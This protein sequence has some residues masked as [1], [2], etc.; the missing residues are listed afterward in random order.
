MKTFKFLLFVI[1]LMFYACHEKPLN[2]AESPYDLVFDELSHTW[3]EGMPLGNAVVGALGWEKDNRLRMSLDRVDLWDLRPSDSLSGPNYKF[4]WVY[5]QVM[6]G[7]YLPVQKKFDHPYD[8]LPAPSKIPGAGLEFPMEKTG[9]PSSVHLY[10]NNA[11]CEISWPN[12]MRMQTFVHAT[13]PVGW[14]IVH[15]A[16]DS[17]VP[18][19]APPVYKDSRKDLNPATG[20][21]LSRL[22][23]DQ[24]VVK[25]EDNMITYRQEG[26]DGFYYDAVVKWERKG[27][28]FTVKVLYFLY[29]K[30]LPHLHIVWLIPVLRDVCFHSEIL[31]ITV[32]SPDTHRNVT[33]GFLSYSFPLSCPATI[34]HFRL[35]Q[36]ATLFPCCR[37]QS[38]QFSIYKGYKPEQPLCYTNLWKGQ[39]GYASMWLPLIGGTANIPSD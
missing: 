13:E 24:G 7:D 27:D 38:K 5:E 34:F 20:Q 22:G 26:W 12:G 33:E 39:A 1:P 28:I 29:S 25:K 2:T 4:K 18:D 10:L 14:F 21:E 16:D 3:D 37:C 23:Y 9:L 35:T 8:Q 15:H 36:S 32:F 30:N 31:Y 19:I 6:K 11:V 17:F